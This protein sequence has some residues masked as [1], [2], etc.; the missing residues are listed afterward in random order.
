MAKIK[1]FKAFT[2]MFVALNLKKLGVLDGIFLSSLVFSL[3]KSNLDKVLQQNKARQNKITQ[4]KQMTI[5]LPK[6]K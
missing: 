2:K 1:Q 6:S 3:S 4:D 5:F